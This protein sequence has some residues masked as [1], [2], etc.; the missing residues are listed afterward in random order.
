MLP[1]RQMMGIDQRFMGWFVERVEVRVRSAGRYADLTLFINGV[2]EDRVQ[3][4][5]Y[6]N[7]LYV[8]GYRAIDRDIGRLQLG[9]NGYQFIESITVFL[10]R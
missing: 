9:V 10:V 2:F 5:G 1:L 6:I 8:R 4:F 7:N 3:P